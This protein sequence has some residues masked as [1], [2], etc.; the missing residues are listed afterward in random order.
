MYKIPTRQHFMPE[1]DYVFYLH[2]FTCTQAV[3]DFPIIEVVKNEL[4]K[5]TQNPPVD[6]D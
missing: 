3:V 6:H 5:S 2:F 4:Q 1:M